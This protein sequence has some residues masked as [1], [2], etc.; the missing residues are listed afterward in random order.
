MN[1]FTYAIVATEREADIGNAATDFRARQIFFNPACSINKIYSIVVM[2][3]NA[4]SNGKDIGVKNNIFRWKADLINENL[5]A[6]LTNFCLALKGICLTHFVKCHHYRCCTVTTNQAC[7][8]SE[9]LFAL[10]E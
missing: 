10:F 2:L 9:R 3:F 1:G 7:L 6:A 5:I 8:F 4:G